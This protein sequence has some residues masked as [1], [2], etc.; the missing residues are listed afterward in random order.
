MEWMRTLQTA[1]N[2]MEEHLLDDINYE[3]VARQVN[4]SSYHFHRTFSFIAG[5]TANEYIR[6]RRLSLAGQELLDTGA[7]VTDVALKYGYDTPESFAKAFT[8]FHGVAPKYAKVSGTRLCLFNPLA[9]KISMEGGKV[10]DYKIVETKKQSYLAMVRPFKNENINDPENHEIPD[11]WQEC[12]EK[13]LVEPLRAM[14]PD[15][16]KDL[17]GLCSPSKKGAD[18]FYYGIG[19]VLDEE[20][21]VTEKEK[22][23]ASGFELWEVEPCTYVVFECMG[24]DG[25]SIDEMWSRYYKEFLPQT[26]YESAD[27]TDYEIYYEKGKAGLFCELWIPIQ[28]K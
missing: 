5:M 2:Y 27:A 14:R 23:L 9:I 8:R 1:I 3:D 16:K 7:K 4:T 24:K 19:I 12:H 28:K 15:G 11:F 26:G 22:M 17:Y 6:N 13:N 25:D 20:T 10:M 21:D 18:Y